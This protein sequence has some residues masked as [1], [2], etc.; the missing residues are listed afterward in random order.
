MNDKCIGSN[1]ESLNALLIYALNNV[2]KLLDVLIDRGIVFHSF[3]V[4]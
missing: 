3:I 1:F 2:F 4:G